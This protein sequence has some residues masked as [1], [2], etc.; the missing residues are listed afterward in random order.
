MAKKPIAIAAFLLR[1]GLAIVFLYAAVSAWINPDAWIGF[2]PPWL[3]AI[4]P[5]TLFLTIYNIFQVALAFWL[6]SG[7]RA[8]EAAIVT[9]ITL[10]AIILLNMGALDLIFR[11]VAILFA[12]GA[13]AALSMRQ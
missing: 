9:G 8:F 2:I 10:A 3:R 4:V 11:D 12:A 1:S 13:L 7:K 6:L 5:G